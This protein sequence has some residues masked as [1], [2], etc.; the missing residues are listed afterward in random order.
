LDTLTTPAIIIL[1]LLHDD[2][3]TGELACN[4]LQEL[5]SLRM[6]EFGKSYGRQEAEMGGYSD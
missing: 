6:C 3:E 2:D 1:L 4:V 5:W